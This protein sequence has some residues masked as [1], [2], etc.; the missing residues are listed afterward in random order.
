M[1]LGYYGTVLYFYLDDTVELK[2]KYF[3]VHNTVLICVL[4][5]VFEAGHG[6]LH[7]TSCSC[8]M[9]CWQVKDVKFD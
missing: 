2:S 9:I 7:C 1:V 3:I 6:I 8:K 5:F 4:V